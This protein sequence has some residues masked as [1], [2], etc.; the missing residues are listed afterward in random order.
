MKKHYRITACK[1]RLT[2]CEVGVFIK[3][4]KIHLPPL[5]EPPKLIICGRI[6]GDWVMCY[7]VFVDMCCSIFSATCVLVV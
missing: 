2:A 4:S 6:L 7:D 1:A 5:E 3:L